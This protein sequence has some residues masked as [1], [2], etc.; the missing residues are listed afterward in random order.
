MAAEGRERAVHQRLEHG[1]A[2]APGRRVPVGW[3]STDLRLRE[4]ERTFTPLP[5]GS[6]VL[7]YDKKNNQ[8]VYN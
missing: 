6:T 3:K 5:T 2:C 8:F 7:R 4:H 1:R